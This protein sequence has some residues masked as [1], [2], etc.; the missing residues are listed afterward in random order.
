MGRPKGPAL[1]ART[2]QDGAFWSVYVRI[3]IFL[4]MPRTVLR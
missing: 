4:V 1:K 3:S 2:Y